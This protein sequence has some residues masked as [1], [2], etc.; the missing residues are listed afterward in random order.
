VVPCSSSHLLPDIVETQAKLAEDRP[1]RPDRDLAAS[2]RYH[3]KPA[4]Q[5]Y[6]DVTAFATVGI[7]GHAQASELPKKFSAVH[8]CRYTS[9]CIKLRSAFTLSRETARILLGGF[10]LG[11]VWIYTVGWAQIP[12]ESR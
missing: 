5:P 3:R 2:C 7:D 6:H 9:G 12:E 10:W 11:K 1:E 4:A 8:Q